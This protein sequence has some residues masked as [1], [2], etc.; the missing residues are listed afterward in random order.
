MK[1]LPCEAWYFYFLRAICYIKKKILF[2]NSDIYMKQSAAKIFNRTDPIKNEEKAQS[3][4]KKPFNVV[5]MK[6]E[7]NN[8]DAPYITWTQW[9]K[10]PENK[11]KSILEFHKLFW[12][13]PIKMVLR[14][15]IYVRKI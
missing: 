1:P 7:Q 15:R 8:S 3:L 12:E 13:E 4:L 11:G 9:R 2:Y 5:S 14:K 10:M 6:T